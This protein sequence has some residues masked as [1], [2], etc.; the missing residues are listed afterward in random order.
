MA[1][2]IQRHVF[3]DDSAGGGGKVAADGDGI[4]V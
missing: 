4:A 2:Q 3:A 1:L